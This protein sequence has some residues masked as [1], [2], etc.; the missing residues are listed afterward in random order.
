MENYDVVIAGA[1]P[2]GLTLAIELGQQGTK[3]LLVD[4][5]PGLGKLPKMERCNARTMENFRRMG[6]ADQIRAAGLDNDMPMDVF[7]CVENVVNPPLVHHVYPSVREL[8]AEYAHTYDGSEPAEP[9]QLIFQYT[10]EP[11]LRD[12][13]ECT[14]G[15]RVVFDRELVDFQQDDMDRA[16][17]GLNE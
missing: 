16:R 4:K 11:V 1:G 3:V 15:V 8:E 2:V 5:R 9:Y 7:I 6:V 13:A 10:L 12:I 14:P 17:V